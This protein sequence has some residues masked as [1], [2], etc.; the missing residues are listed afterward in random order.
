[1]R[2]KYLFTTAITLGFCLFVSPVYAGKARVRVYF[3]PR[4]GA[5]KAI[6]QLIRSAREEIL[7]AIYMFTNRA[8][9]GKLIDAAKRGVRVS[10]LL[11]AKQKN[12]PYSQAKTL[13]RYR[14]DIRY[15]IPR[16]GKGADTRWSKFHH[17]F[18][19]IDK[20]WV[21]TGSYNWT[22]AA[23]TK[24]QENLLVI[25]SKSLAKQYRKEFLKYHKI[26]KRPV[27][28]R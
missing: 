23:E 3:S 4:G 28:R 22:G 19:V 15:V 24:N 8:I 9:A 11:D 14:I 5:E 21:I 13:E 6:L 10:V 26:A 7:V 2:S 18:A 17:K 20:K 1:M 27:Q 16:R 25:Y 12:I